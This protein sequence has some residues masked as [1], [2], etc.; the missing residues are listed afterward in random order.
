MPIDAKE[1]ERRRALVKAHYAAENDH[2][3]DRIMDTF[4]ADGVMLYPPQA[5]DGM[6]GRADG[7]QKSRHILYTQGCP[8]WKPTPPPQAPRLPVG[9]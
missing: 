5:P 2:D 9:A 3:L 4:A 1:K 8:G 7:L 6:N